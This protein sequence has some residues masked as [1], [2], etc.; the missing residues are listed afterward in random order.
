MKFLRQLNQQFEDPPL[1][2]RELPGGVTLLMEP[3]HE[4]TSLAIGVWVRTGS[5]DE[6]PE[7][8]GI[9]HLIEH[10]VFKGTRRHSGYKL[11]KRMEAIGG[12]IDAY[13]TKECTCF[14][15]RVFEGHRR[16][17]V[18]ILAELLSQP[19]LSADM[20]ESEIGVVEEEIQS[21]EDSPEEMIHDL[22][23][24]VLWNRHPLGIPILGTR[25]SLRRL[26]ARDVR[27]YHRGRYAGPNVVVAAAGRIDDGAL[28]EEVAR[29]F[30]LPKAIEPADHHRLPRFHATERHEE[31]D[32]SQASICLVRRGPSYRDRDRH[33][34]YI[35]NTILGAGAS[36]R[37]YQTIREQ[38]GLAYSIYSYADS[39]RDTGMFGIYLAVSPDRARRALSLICRELR[40]IKRDGARNWELESAKAQ[41]FTGMFLSYESMY[42]RISRLS[43][44]HLYYGRQIPLRDT[45]RAL[46]QIT[47]DD[48][49][50]AAEKMIQASEYSVVTLGPRDCNPPGLAELDF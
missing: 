8:A 15:A 43:H 22:S 11:A 6:H 41:I 16:E 2:Q 9:T 28:L 19:S 23:A 37:L 18:E 38:A 25:A 40:R 36:S 3:V 44:N 27:R 50:E 49:H 31:R 39:F 46:E 26:T 29:S 35:L 20:I 24:E 42:E 5:R 4:V 30:R 32:V 48:V 12:Q 1:L 45:V 7:Q 21:Y 14:Y 13:T 17:A 33:A 10:L 47:L 34:V